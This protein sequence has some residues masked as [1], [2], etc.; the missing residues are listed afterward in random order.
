MCGKSLAI[1]YKEKMFIKSQYVEESTIRALSAIKK[2][3]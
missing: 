2:A 1:N 3:N